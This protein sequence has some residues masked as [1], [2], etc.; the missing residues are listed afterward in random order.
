MSSENT[1][2]WLCQKCKQRFMVALDEHK[3]CIDSRE[4]MFPSC[5]NCGEKYSIA[6]DV[7]LGRESLPKWIDMKNPNVKIH[8]EIALIREITFDGKGRASDKC[9]GNCNQFTIPLGG[10]H[11]CT[12]YNQEVDQKDLCDYWFERK[13]FS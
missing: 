6:I 9:C 13:V 10:K 7:L 12:K 5:S 2:E 11:W 3:R 1:K 8:N 4:K